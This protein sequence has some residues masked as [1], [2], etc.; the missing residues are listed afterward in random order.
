MKTSKI[1]LSYMPN[2]VV[3]MIFKEIH[4]N[5]FLALKQ[6]FH[7]MRDPLR[8]PHPRAIGNKVVGASS[9]HA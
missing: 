1:K 2:E 5:S 9:V 3:N 4:C 7:Y 8:N 6:G